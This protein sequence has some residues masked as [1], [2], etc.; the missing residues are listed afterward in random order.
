MKNVFVR[1]LLLL[2]LFIGSSTTALAE[3]FTVNRIRYT[4]IKDSHYCSVASG[5]IYTGDIVIP[6]EV[7][8]KSTTYKVVSVDPSAFSDKITLMSVT[9]PATVVM[10]G[11]KA[12]DGC[13]GLKSINLNNCVMIDTYAFKG[14]KALQEV[15]LDSCG[16]ICKYAFQNCTSLKTVTTHV[17]D[18]YGTYVGDYAFENCT[19]LSSANY[20]NILCYLGD[21]AFKNCT[22][23]QSMTALGVKSMY[24]QTTEPD[25]LNNYVF[26]GCSSLEHLQFGVSRYGIKV[27]D[28]AFYGCSSLKSVPWWEQT[29]KV[30]ASAFEGSGVVSIPTNSIEE[31][32]AKGF[33]DCAY[34][35][36]A[37]LYSV[38][39]LG[40]QTFSNCSG[41]KELILGDNFQTYSSNT[42]E[43]CS[44]FQKVACGS[45]SCNWDFAK[46]LSSSTNLYIRPSVCD[47]V[48]VVTQAQLYML[49]GNKT[50][51]YYYFDDIKSRLTS[52]SFTVKDLRGNA[53]STSCGITDPTD[54]T[55]RIYP[56]STGQYTFT[57][58][59]R[60]TE[61]TF[62]TYYSDEEIKFKTSTPTVTMSA[63]TWLAA[64]ST[65]VSAF[66]N[67]TDDVL[68]EL[69]IMQDNNRIAQIGDSI[70]RSGF[71]IGSAQKVKPY[72]V[73]NDKDYVY[74]DEQIITLN[75]LT[76]AI[77][78]ETTDLTQTK[79]TLHITV[80]PDTT[81]TVTRIRYKIDDAASYKLL[82]Q[83]GNISVE[84]MVP[85][86]AFSCEVYVRCSEGTG[87]KTATFK[88]KTLSPKVST[89]LTSTTAKLT[90]AYTIIDATKKD[91]YFTVNGTKYEGNELFLT[92]LTPDSTYKVTYTV[93]SEEGTTETKTATFKTPSLTLTTLQPKV[94][95]NGCAVVAASTN[96]SDKETNVGF[97]WIKYQYKDIPTMAPKEGNAAVYDGNMEAYIKNLQSEAYNVRS[98]YKSATGKYYYGEWITFDP[99]DFS[100]LEPTVHTYEALEAS[101]NVAKVKGYVMQGTDDIIEQ[102]FEYWGANTSQAKA[103]RVKF[104]ASENTAT[105][106]SSGQVMTAELTNLLSG[107]AYSFRAYASTT[108]G[109]TYGEEQ[110]FTTLGVSGIAD[111][112]DCEQEVKIEGYYD[113]SGRKYD[114]P[115]PGITI[116]RYTDGT[117]RKI[118]KK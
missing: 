58:L 11:S 7:T 94:V 116:I 42:F 1:H 14:C 71:R 107:T 70:Y 35:A 49:D 67:S 5:G 101:E 16:Y 20:N 87:D 28:Y 72:A 74:G 10:I 83:D 45:K 18:Y 22:S 73:F 57:R 25:T 111:V 54:P 103:Q 110:S 63:N 104:A 39:T 60:A 84:G 4:I 69:G 61:Y 93:T 89:S 81:V 95:S 109:T 65:R 108:N 78:I 75:Q 88:T 76:D 114:K 19:S 15:T 90:G 99:T 52:I 43:R 13:T 117:T 80:S 38:K 24:N 113:L 85:G 3:T 8:Y 79:A 30:G 50:Y 9:L 91:D 47:N 53:I 26:Y 12:F 55:S 56:N 37:S 92:S 48:K 23:L 34:L 6:E 44:G 97:Q 118:A 115:Q 106:I 41:L 59:S 86:Q 40:K 36:T 51:G 32:G 62:R 100:Y 66:T 68:K 98:F 112:T 33:K 29:V 77:K 102:G 46:G 96:I 17:P 27:G 2:L 21:G 31:I 64:Y 105:V 82:P